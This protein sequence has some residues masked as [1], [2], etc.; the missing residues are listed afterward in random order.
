MSELEKS[1]IEFMV[2]NNHPGIRYK[3]ILLLKEEKGSM[4]LP[5]KKQKILDTLRR[6][7]VTPVVEQQIRDI[8]DQKTPDTRDI[9]L[10]VIANSAA[11]EG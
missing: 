3:E 10:K 8:L 11:K 9:K 2:D 1:L 5:Q 6:A 7:N 4:K